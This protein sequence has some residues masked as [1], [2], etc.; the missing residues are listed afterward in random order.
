MVC[1][2]LMPVISIIFGIVVPALKSWIKASFFGFFIL[3]SSCRPN[4][5]PRFLEASIPDLHPF[6]IRLLLY[7][8]SDTSICMVNLTTTEEVSILS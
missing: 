7:L 3:L 4:L 1:F 2:I 5:K 8:A 6:N